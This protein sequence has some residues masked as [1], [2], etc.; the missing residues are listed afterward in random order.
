MELEDDESDSDIDVIDEDVETTR[1]TV[2]FSSTK[3]NLSLEL[4]ECVDTSV[5]QEGLK[6]EAQNKK[7]KWGLIL[8]Q[9]R[10]RRHTEDGRTMLQKATD[11]KS[12]KNLDIAHERNPGI[13]FNTLGNSHLHDIAVK[14]N[15]NVGN[16]CQDALQNIDVLKH[17]EKMKCS[18]FIE[19]NPGIALPV[20]LDLDHEVNAENQN[21][22]SSEHEIEQRSYKESWS[23]VV[24]RGIKPPSNEIVSNERCLLEH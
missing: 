22:M 5:Q 12:F 23:Q 7:Q 15:I 2:D 20:N 17:T 16:T 8:L 19:A 13:S 3:R 21:N 10:P 9:E 18:T 24:Q 11:L 14:V 1:P 4:E 6:Q